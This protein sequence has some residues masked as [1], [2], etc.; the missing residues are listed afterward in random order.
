M[1]EEKQARVGQGW[2]V[3][4][5]C[6]AF[7]LL[8]GILSLYIGTTTLSSRH[9]SATF[10]EI[11]LSSAGARGYVTG[12]FDLVKYYHPRVM[13]YLYGLPVVASG[14]K[15]PDEARFTGDRFAFN[16]AQEL[17][18]EG[19]SDPE[20]LIFRTRLVGVATGAFLVFL[21]FLFG[22]RFYGP[23]AAVASA[24]MMAFLPDLLAH[25]GIAYNDV[26]AALTI[27][28][29]VWCLDRACRQPSVGTIS[30]ASLAVA[31]ALGVK[32]S[33]LVLGPIGFL[34]VG[35]EAIS[36]KGEWQRYL[37]S[38]LPF[39]Y[40][41]LGVLYLATVAIYL[42][43]LTLASFRTGLVFSL[44]QVGQGQPASPWLLGESY[45]G[46]TWKYFPLAFLIK[47]P[48]ALQALL[49][50]GLIGLLLRPSARRNWLESPLRGPIVATAVLIPV[51]ITSQLN[52]GFRHALPLLPFLIVIASAGLQRLW[53]TR[54]PMIQG[55]VTA[56]LAVQALSVL[57]WYPHF[58]PYTSEYFPGKDSGHLLLTD[59]NHDW[60]QGLLVLRDFME[61]EGIPTVYLSY[62]GSAWPEAYGI[63]HV[64]LPSFF[65]LP[66][67]PWPESPPEYVVV[68]ATNVVGGYVDGRFR[69]LLLVPPE[70]VLAHTLFVYRSE[71]VLALGVELPDAEMA[72]GT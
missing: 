30:L 15:Y 58:I 24:G 34:L 55:L 49:L 43:D 45:S 18:W 51:L 38:L 13:P 16:Y 70:E 6:R 10:D 28:G 48:V 17:F 68:S 46:G 71:D 5:R 65:P 39:A 29:A 31:L 53:E 14:P 37:W 11:L 69:E 19:G 32:Y 41:S 36:R 26:A 8:L 23:A 27:F 9:T 50:L 4:G 42:G 62:F 44:Q 72:E 66:D 63:G 21:V 22:Y 56:L 47:V 12:D 35:V 61:E 67:Q 60:G 3:P 57:S 40:L 20:K 33:A 52:I 7:L 1:R 25:G 64:P 2:C 59:S 54:R